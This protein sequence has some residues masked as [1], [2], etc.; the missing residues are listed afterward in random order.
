MNEL[1]LNLLVQRLMHITGIDEAD[2][3]VID[4][5]DVLLTCLCCHKGR[6]SF[7]FSDRDFPSFSL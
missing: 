2:L 1:I 3:L 5:N 4:L 7:V 6:H